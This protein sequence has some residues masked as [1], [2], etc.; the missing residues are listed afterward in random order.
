VALFEEERRKKA[1]EKR[2]LRKKRDAAPA[3][4]QQADYI[5][6]ACGKACHF[7]IGLLSLQRMHKTTIFAK[8]V[9]TI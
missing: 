2:Q 1:E 4:P 6:P 9:E 3:L 5:C 7:R 8:I